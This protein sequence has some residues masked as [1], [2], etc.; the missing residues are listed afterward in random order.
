MTRTVGIVGAGITG[1]LLHRSLRVRGYETIVLE[2]AEEPGGVIRSRLVDSR[3]LETGPQRLRETPAIRKLVADLG[4]ESDRIEAED[5]PL[6]VYFDGALRTAPLSVS[7][8]LRTDLL[9]IRGKAR[10]LLEPVL[11][12]PTR[13]GESVEE[14]LT[15]TFGSEFAVRFGGPLYAGLYGSDP[16]TMPVEHSLAR[17]IDRMGI[18]GSVLAWAARR[19]LR[20]GSPPPI[21]SFRDGLQTLP[22]AIADQYP[23]GIRFG[24]PVS[25][26]TADGDGYR[27]RTDEANYAVDAAVLTVPAPVAAALVADLAPSASEALAALT[28]NPLATVHLDARDVEGTAA[29]HTIPLGEGMLTRGVTWNGSLFERDTRNGIHTCFLGGAGRDPLRTW[30]DDELG[31]RARE[32]F[33]TVTGTTGAVLD[34]HRVQPGMPAYD[35][36]WA[37]LDRVELPADVHLCANYTARAGIPGRVRAAHEL[38]AELDDG[39]TGHDRSNESTRART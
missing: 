38:A 31:R 6:Y 20:G 21:V 28:Y 14:Y 26:I 13:A 8:A 34:V 23:A 17:A 18:D 2:A 12:G 11:G 3:V 9:S 15:R 27:M 37:A 35:R 4:L 10:V 29:G 36:S 39:S 16:A 24:E 19:R 22:A 7:A 25:A 32:E 1:L 33:Q 5:R 30:S